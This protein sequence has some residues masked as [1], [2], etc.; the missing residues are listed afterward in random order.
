MSAGRNTRGG[1]GPGS[2]SRVLSEAMSRPRGRGRFSDDTVERAHKHTI[3]PADD[4]RASGLSEL[5]PVLP[6]HLHPGTQ[7]CKYPL[8]LIQITEAVG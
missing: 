4:I 6:F 7:V 8:E 1:R 2:S 3:F 5:V